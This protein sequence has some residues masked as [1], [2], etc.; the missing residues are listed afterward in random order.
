MNFCSYRSETNQL[1]FISEYPIIMIGTYT[2]LTIV[3]R[4]RNPPMLVTSG[5]RTRQDSA[6]SI[7]KADFHIHENA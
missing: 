2:H 5:A 4:V 6:I 3:V 7:F 1:T